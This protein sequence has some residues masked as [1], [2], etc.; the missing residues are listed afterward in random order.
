MSQSIRRELRIPHAIEQVW[1]SIANRDALAEWMYP[2]DFEPRVGHQFTFQVPP[3]PHV[4]FDGLIVE[5][6]VLVCDPPHRLVFSWSAGGPV[7]DTRV[8]FELETDG[9]GTLLG[10]EH[11]GFD[12]TRPWGAEAL[13]GATF[14]WATMLEKLSALV[15]KLS[16]DPT[17]E[18][19]HEN[20]S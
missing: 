18:S 14:G 5:C 7:V 1:Q 6:E 2:N 13:Q 20:G 4:G 17:T 9:D 8:S 16:I 11:S 3:N 12:V 10:F 19:R 15:G